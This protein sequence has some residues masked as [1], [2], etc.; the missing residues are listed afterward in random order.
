MWH[1]P[2][3]VWNYGSWSGFLKI[4]TKQYL[5][6][7]KNTLYKILSVDPILTP[8]IYIENVK[9]YAKSICILLYGI[10]KNNHQNW[11]KIKHST[12]KKHMFFGILWPL[13]SAVDFLSGGG[14]INFVEDHPMNISTRFDFNCSVRDQHPKS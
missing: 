3:N 7:N 1:S 9:C 11:L 12:Y 5:I 6:R 2:N 10:K 14:N 8:L 13:V 4:K